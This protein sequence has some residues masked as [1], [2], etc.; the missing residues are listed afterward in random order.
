MIEWWTVTFMGV[1][2]YDQKIISINS[3]FFWSFFLLI[4]F[5][6]QLL[7]F[8]PNSLFCWYSFLDT[9]CT[10]TTLVQR[11][12]IFLYFFKLYGRKLHSNRLSLFP[13]SLVFLSVRTLKQYK[14]SF[15]VKIRLSLHL[16]Q[17]QFNGFSTKKLPENN[18][19]KGC[20]NLILKREL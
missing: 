9:P 13:L 15:V 12:K 1:K 18:P 2:R 20:K 5:W 14:V 3:E 11:K 6:R 8:I 10:K 17:K 16:L 19:E 4:V 7:S